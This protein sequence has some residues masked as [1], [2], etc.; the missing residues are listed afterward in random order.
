[1]DQF[2]V[3]CQAPWLIKE[4]ILELQKIQIRGKENSRENVT[5]IISSQIEVFSYLL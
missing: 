1:M 4:T 2:L 3:A 5:D